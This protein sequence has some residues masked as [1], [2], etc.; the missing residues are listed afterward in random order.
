MPKINN[1][2]NPRTKIEVILQKKKWTQK[3]FL[4]KYNETHPMTP[5]M[6]YHFSKIVSGKLTRLNL[7]TIYKIC[8]VLNKTPNDILDWEKHLDLKK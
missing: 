1:N 3:K 4:Q 8:Y 6:P 5:M 2:N 7:E